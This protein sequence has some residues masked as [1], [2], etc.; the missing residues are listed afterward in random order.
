MYP[1]EK[2]LFSN[3]IDH[4]HGPHPPPL[5]F[6]PVGSPEGT[7]PPCKRVPNCPEGTKR[8]VLLEPAR[9]RSLKGRLYGV[10][11]PVYP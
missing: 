8:L 7:L 4:H 6:L 5:G 2:T 10:R 3:N 9:W 1:N 11:V